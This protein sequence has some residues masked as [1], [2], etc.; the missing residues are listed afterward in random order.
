MERWRDLKEKLQVIFT[1]N[2]NENPLSLICLL[3]QQVIT[4]QFN[5]FIHAKSSSIHK[6]SITLYLPT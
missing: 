2:V 1:E 6:K 3:V 4:E 5:L